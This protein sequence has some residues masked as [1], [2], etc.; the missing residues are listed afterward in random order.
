VKRAA[1]R[2]PRPG[3]RVLRLTALRSVF[4]LLGPLA[5][6]LAARLALRLFLTPPARPRVTP[7]ERECMRLAT[8]IDMP[9][10][11]VAAWSW[12]Q[13]PAVLLV[14]GWGGRGSQMCAFVAPLVEAGFKVVSFDGPAH[15]ESSGVRTDMIAFVA[16]IKS[17]IAHLGGIEAII[18]HSFGAAC[19]LLAS[20][21]QQHLA[22]KLV[23]I[24][25]PPNGIWMSEQFGAA[26]G[27]SPVILARMR[28]LLE[29]RYP[30]I[31]DW[32][33]LSMLKMAA[34]SPH[35]LLLVHDKDDRTVPY[36]EA[37]ACFMREAPE[38]E[39]VATEGL[40]HRGALKAAAAIDRTVRFIT[41]P[42]AAPEA[43]RDEVIAIP[44][45]N[46]EFEC[47]LRAI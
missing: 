27:V 4:A 24:G 33:E 29:E 37:A 6:G 36:A 17:V 3:K 40:G 21:D 41:H 38:I 7:E 26:L 23:L 25:C 22:K 32:A 11:G 16:A 12:G 39:H 35:P 19:A 8:R 1:S 42:H 31:L 47:L 13:G 20:R 46:S 14:H 2:R 45:C 28:A 10:A 43:A 34:R 44:R 9:L 5:P 18:G 30:G 15:G